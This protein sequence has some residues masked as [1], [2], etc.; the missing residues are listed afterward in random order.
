M[1]GSAARAASTAMGGSPDEASFR[2]AGWR[3][4]GVC[5]L[6]AMFAWAL[7]FYG[8]SVYLAELQ[9]MHGWPA[10]AISTATTCF[11][12]FS[13]G[14]VVFVGE[15]MRALGARLLLSGAVLCMAVAAVLLARVT[16]VWQLYAVYALMAFGW[17]GLTV[18]AISNTL[19]QWFDRRR[20][21]A[22][23]LALNG[24]SIGGVIGVPG[25]VT[26]VGL[27]GFTSA[28]TAA[29]VV[30]VVV[31]LPVIW[32]GV[33]R[34]PHRSIAHAGHAAPAALTPHQIRGEAMREL[35]FWT[36]ALPFALVLLAQVGF[37]VHQIA[38]MSPTIGREHAG[39]AVAVM[40]GMAVLGRVLIGTVI[41]RSDQRMV[42]AV[43]FASQ[44]VSIAA[45]IAIPGEIVLFAASGLF[46]FTVGNA[47]TLPAVIVHHEFDSA[48]FGVVV[49]LSSA[50]TSVISACGAALVGALH[51]YFGGYDTALAVCMVLEII[52]ACCVLIGRQRPAR[53]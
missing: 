13:A 50:I 20:G 35:R 47:I 22:I 52:A 49:S 41:D 43:L 4:V 26:A 5:F 12:L 32:L 9:R 8:Q 51:D 40:T 44:A 16:A 11:Y 27:V 19:G 24:A 29:A 33:G 34:P 53:A 1:E 7:G 21:L 28:L 14:L 25:L 46:G 38:F 15:A 2:Y 6:A 39:L 18:A 23:S 31:L 48:R 10:S 36:I 37:I 30:M 3:V 45:M 42:S 17:A